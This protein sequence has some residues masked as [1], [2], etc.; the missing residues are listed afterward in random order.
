MQ[1]YPYRINIAGNPN[2]GKW[3]FRRARSYRRVTTPFTFLPDSY[4]STISAN[5]VNP[6]NPNWVGN[7]YQNF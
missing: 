3:V 5:W 4:Y 1:L 6:N 7:P 2:N